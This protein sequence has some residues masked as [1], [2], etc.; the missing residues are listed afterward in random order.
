MDSLIKEERYVSS[1]GPVEHVLLVQEQIRGS[2]PWPERFRVQ[3]PASPTRPA[4]TIY[5]S[6]AREAVERAVEYLFLWVPM[7]KELVHLRIC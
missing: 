3:V 6:T 2:E 7:V 1:I 4:R 5:G